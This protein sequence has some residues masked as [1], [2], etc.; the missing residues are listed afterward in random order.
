MRAKLAFVLGCVILTAAGAQMLNAGGQ[1]GLPAPKFTA[2]PVNGKQVNLAS[3]IDPNG[4]VLALADPRNRDGARLVAYLQQSQTQLTA[5]KVG[6]MVIALGYSQRSSV[7]SLAKDNKLTVPLAAD[8]NGK[9]AKA[10]GV[11]T[12]A[13]VLVIDPDGNVF[14]RL[15]A[16]NDSTDLGPLAMAAVTDMLEKFAK[17]DDGEAIPEATPADQPDAKAD[18]AKAKLSEEAVRKRIAAGW[19]L[20]QLGYREA[21]LTDARALAEQQGRDF[22][23]SLWLAYAL[24]AAMHYP[25]AAVTYREVLKLQP[26][27]LYARTAIARIDPTGRYLTKADLPQ[28]VA[29]EGADAE[30]TTSE[31]PAAVGG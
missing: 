8:D 10:F 2:R 23:T 31:G 7:E 15:E 30:P 3:L 14:K 13:V 28:P 6:V 24:E 19:K 1:E 21:A 27:N 26:G 4:G 18:A 16:T 20:L 5:M 17:A 22:Q 12:S 11:A 29:A 9:F 25:E